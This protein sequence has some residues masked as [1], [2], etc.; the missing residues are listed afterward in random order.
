MGKYVNGIKVSDGNGNGMGMGMNSL[1]WE[2]IGMKNL[3]PHISSLERCSSWT[4][5]HA[6]CTNA[7]SSGV[8]FRK[9][10]KAL[11]KGDGKAKHRLILQ[12]L[13]NTSAKNYHNRIVYVKITASY[14]WDVF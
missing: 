5:L 3:F 4:V 13:R 12:F 7:L 2:G 10:A 8:F 11:E 1:I 14:R 9:N 6:Q